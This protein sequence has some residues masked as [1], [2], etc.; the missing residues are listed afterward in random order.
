MSTPFAQKLEIAK[1]IFGKKLKGEKKYPL[2]MELEPL[3]QCNLACAGC[4]KIQHPAET[5]RKRL[6]V[7]D[8]VA[9]VEEC[10]AP[11]ISIAG[12]EPLVY[13]ELPRLVDELIK[14]LI[15]CSLYMRGLL[16]IESNQS[17]M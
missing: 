9:A 12:G 1:Y 7:E 6:S 10:G 17:E 3:F 11:V 16:K 13:E 14:A 2:V 4:G 5:L 15:R 8:C